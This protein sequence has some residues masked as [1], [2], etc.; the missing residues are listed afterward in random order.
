MGVNSFWLA[1][2]FGSFAVLIFLLF[3]P[4]TEDIEESNRSIDDWKLS[5]RRR[6]MPCYGHHDWVVSDKG[7][8]NC[9]KCKYEHPEEEHNDNSQ[10]PL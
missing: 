6:N 4:T 2:F 5:V 9:R 3:V 1:M 7:L 8:R 10:T